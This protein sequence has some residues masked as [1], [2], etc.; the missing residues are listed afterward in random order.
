MPSAHPPHL[1]Q[2]DRDG[3]AGS[4]AARRPHGHRGTVE[5]VRQAAVYSA[6][7]EVAYGA[8]EMF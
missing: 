1:S 7:R 3:I 4:T 6:L 2:P 5:N 8:C